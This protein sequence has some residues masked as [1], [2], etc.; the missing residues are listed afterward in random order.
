ML[1][2]SVQHILVI[3][4]LLSRLE[5]LLSFLDLDFVSVLGDILPAKFCRPCFA[6]LTCFV[7]AESALCRFV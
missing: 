4:S 2:I 5:V 1:F 3:E 6:A 7:N